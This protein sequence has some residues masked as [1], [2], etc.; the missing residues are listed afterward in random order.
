MSQQPAEQSQKPAAGTPAQEKSP[1][2]AAPEKKEPPPSAKKAE[3]EVTG[4][5]LGRAIAILTKAAQQGRLP[6][7]P[8]GREL[9]LDATDLAISYSLVVVAAEGAVVARV[10]GLQPF[11]GQLSRELLSDTV[12][13]VESF[14]ETQIA[15]PLRLKLQSAVTEL[16]RPPTVREVQELSGFPDPDMPFLPSPV[17]KADTIQDDDDPPTSDR[18]T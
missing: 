16:S 15:R 6:K 10:Q 5:E 4:E 14:L 11:Y 18:G 12:G 17:V 9:G 3:A 8:D 13:A 7:V 1:K 2:K